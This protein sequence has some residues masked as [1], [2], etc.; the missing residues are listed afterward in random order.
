MTS[1]CRQDTSSVR[2]D[3]GIIVPFEYCLLKTKRLGLKMP[4][5]GSQPVH[6]TSLR[7][8]LA[9]LISSI[10]N[11]RN[12]NNT[13]TLW[14]Q[15]RSISE[16]ECLLRKLKVPGSSTC[17]TRHAHLYLSPGAVGTGKGVVLGACWLLVYIQ[18][19]LGLYLKDQAEQQKRI[20]HILLWPVRLLLPRFT[21]LHTSVYTTYINTS[22]REENY[23]LS[24][25]LFCCGEEIP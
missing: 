1:K 15:R 24:Q 20:P 2:E 17:T 6:P 23:H 5:S 13:T 7:P 22:E 11:H 25:S 10:A 12:Y 21:Y 16:E 18:F 3:S 19:C 4:L 14:G 9:F 8:F